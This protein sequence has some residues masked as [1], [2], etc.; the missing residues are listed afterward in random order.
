MP[1]EDE[2]SR[3]KLRVA[4]GFEKLLSSTIWTALW[5]GICFIG[6]AWSFTSH[7]L[8]VL[9]I[10]WVIYPILRVRAVRRHPV[11]ELLLS[12]IMKT[13]NLSYMYHK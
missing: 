5:H 9:M 10:A 4:L 8:E 6:T 13:F 11:L 12:F 3:V 2:E 7:L 1:S